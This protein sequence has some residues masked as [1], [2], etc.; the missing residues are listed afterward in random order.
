MQD[1][2]SNPPPDEPEVLEFKEDFKFIPQGR[3]TWRQEG[4]YLVCRGCELHHAVWVGMEQLMVG[5]DNEGKP[6]LKSRQE[7]FGI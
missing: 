4:P 6:I 7:V 5:E 2:P 1:K 3:H